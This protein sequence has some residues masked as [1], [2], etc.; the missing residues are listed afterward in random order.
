MNSQSLVGAKCP[1]YIWSFN[2]HVVVSGKHIQT[3]VG[4]YT[5]TTH[6]HPFTDHW[7]FSIPC[8]ILSPFVVICFQGTPQLTFRGPLFSIQAQESD[9]Q[10]CATVV[11][12]E[13]DV[14]D[15]D[16]ESFQY[17]TFVVNSPVFGDGPAAGETY[18]VLVSLK[19]KPPI[20]SIDRHVFAW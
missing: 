20:H 11:R 17:S 15:E 1:Y 18:I 10:L 3:H 7:E 14:N 4:M 2:M 9:R 8:P 12:D 16:F 6:P 19:K 13:A 5:P